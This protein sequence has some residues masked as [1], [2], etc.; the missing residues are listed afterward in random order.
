MAEDVRPLDADGQLLLLARLLQ[1][2]GHLADGGGAG[3]GVHQHDHG[4]IVLEHGLADVQNVDVVLGQQGTHSGGD[5]HPVL[6]DDGNNGFHSG[7]FLSVYKI[8]I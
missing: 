4:E 5:A 2:V 1:Q 6:A 7:M 3:G 8:M